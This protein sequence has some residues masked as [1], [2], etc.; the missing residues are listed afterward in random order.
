MIL[1]PL[2]QVELSSATESFPTIA[3]LDS[4]ATDTFIP[5]EMAE[6]LDL[7]S[8]QNPEIP[9]NTAGGVSQF[10]AARLKKLSIIAGG[11]IFCDF[12]NYVVLVPSPTNDLPYVILG[13]DS[14][15]K[16]FHVTFKE[17]IKKFTV[18]HHKYAH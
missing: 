18:V 15:F 16:R 4:G 9:V 12:A 6:M 7:V 10:R 5:Y 8:T 17:K 1:L 2:I 14:L 3:L 13:R 11:K